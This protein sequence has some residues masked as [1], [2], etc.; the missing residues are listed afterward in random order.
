MQTVTSGLGG[1]RHTPV[2]AQVRGLCAVQPA[3]PV[4]GLCP[5]YAGHA[6][7][8][9]RGPSLSTQLVC[10]RVTAQVQQPRKEAPHTQ[11]P[12]RDRPREAVGAGW[13][14]RAGTWEP[15]TEGH[16]TRVPGARDAA[17]MFAVS[18]LSPHGARQAR[19]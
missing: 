17:R 12:R 10:E 19:R 6:G 13:G 9:A 18:G 1:T 14:G 16:S 8:P 11:H 2:S 3:R 15:S 4:R 7:P 5:A